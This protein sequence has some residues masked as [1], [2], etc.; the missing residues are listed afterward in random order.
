MEAADRPHVRIFLKEGKL[1][2]SKVSKKTPQRIGTL[3]GDFAIFLGVVLS[4]S[5]FGALLRDTSLFGKSLRTT[6]AEVPPFQPSLAQGFGWTTIWCLCLLQEVSRYSLEWYCIVAF[7]G[8]FTLDVSWRVVFLFF[9]NWNWTCFSALCI[10]CVGSIWTHGS[11][12][13]YFD[14][15]V[16][17]T[18]RPSWG[19]YSSGVCKG[20]WVGGPSTRR[21]G[22]KKGMEG[23][24][25]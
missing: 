3:K 9:R 5:N 25:F 24:D 23:G 19:N 7:A 2:V 10:D 21:T 4:A 22:R 17:P 11:Y 14:D 1:Q 6:N 20:W 13:I 16:S 12:G 8:E 15:E 18:I